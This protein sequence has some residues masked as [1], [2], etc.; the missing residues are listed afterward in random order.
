MARTAQV[1]RPA[2]AQS[3]GQIR[4]EIIMIKLPMDSYTFKRLR[5]GLKLDREQLSLALSL[6]PRHVERYEIGV[7]PIPDRTAKLMIMFARH[8]VPNDFLQEEAA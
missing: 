2:G 1:Q 4:L 3:R 7:Y 8:G 5:K 6:G